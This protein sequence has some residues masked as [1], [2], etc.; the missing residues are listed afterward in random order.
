MK[1]REDRQ[2]RRKVR[3]QIQIDGI[4]PAALEGLPGDLRLM[5]RHPRRHKLGVLTLRQVLE[6][7]RQGHKVVVF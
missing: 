7:K 4:E 3:Q 2:D 1:N 5:T 6:L